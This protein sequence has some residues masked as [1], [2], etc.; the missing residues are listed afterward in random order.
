M[1]YAIKADMLA[2][3][4]AADLVQLT[5]HVQPFTGGIVDAILDNALSDAA[6]TIDLYLGGRYD[7]PLS[8]TP[9][10]LVD[11]CCTLA[12]YRLNRGRYTD[13]LR[14]DYDDAIKT[15]EQI[16][17]GKIALDQ[18]GQEPASAAAIAQVD[19]PNRIFNRE[20]LKGF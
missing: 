7:L 5:D 13:D 20:S 4:E 16:S 15:L 11:L 1:P 19:G 8:S 9:A 14:K 2:R 6:A 12:F 10:A 17:T 3:Y 18:G